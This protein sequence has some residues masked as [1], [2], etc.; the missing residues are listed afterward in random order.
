MLFIYVKIILGVSMSRKEV[1]Q[2][3]EEEILNSDILSINLMEDNSLELISPAIRTLFSLLFA[4]KKIKITS[5]FKTDYVSSVKNLYIDVNGTQLLRKKK[6]NKQDLVP[7]I[8]GSLGANEVISTYIKLEQDKRLMNLIDQNDV[9]LSFSNLYYHKKDERII[10]VAPI[11]LFKIKVSQYKDEYYLELDYNAPLFNEPLKYLLKDQFDIDISYYYETFD[12]FEY[13]KFI[14]SKLEGTVFALDDALMIL[15]CNV[16]NSNRLAYLVDNKDKLIHTDV[17]R[18]IDEPQEE[19]KAINEYHFSH[20]KYIRDS[21]NKLNANPVTKISKDSKLGM[22]FIKDLIDEYVLS[23]KN[24]LVLSGNEEKNKNTRKTLINSY[25]DMYMSYKDMTKPNTAIYTPLESLQRKRSYFLDADVS[26][27]TLDLTDTLDKK[28]NYDV[29]LKGIQLPTLEDNITIFNNYF[30]YLNLATKLYNLDEFKEYTNENYLKD[31]A[32]LLTL[33]TNPFF[34]D[35]PISKHPFDGLNNELNERDYEKIV[36]FLT[37]F[38]EDINELRKL[39]ELIKIK[40]TNWSKYNRLSELVDHLS[41]FDLLHTYNGFDTMFFSI[42]DNEPLRENLKI[43][44]EC[45]RKEAS[46]KLAINISTNEKIWTL[47]FKEILDNLKGREEKATRKLI[48]SLLKLNTRPNY[49]SLIVLIDKYEENRETMAEVLPTLPLELN[50]Y[51]NDVDG[52]NFIEDALDFIKALKLLVTST[53]LDFDND[54]IKTL[55]TDKEFADNFNRTYFDELVNGLETYRH[56]AS[57]YKKYFPGD[58]TSFSSTAFYDI[59]KLLEKRLNGNEEQFGEYLIFSKQASEASEQLQFA[60]DQEDEN[61]ISLKDF[62][63]NYM[64]SLYQ[65]LLKRAMKENDGVKLIEDQSENN[66]E[67]Y[68]KIKENGEMLHTKMNDE[69]EPLRKKITLQDSYNMLLKKLKDRYHKDRYFSIKDA[70]KLA[71]PYY[72]KVYPLE[73]KSIDFVDSLG[74][75]KFDLVIM[76]VDKDTT[77]LDIFTALRFSSKVL[78]F[79]DDNEIIK[80]VAEIKFNLNDDIG[81]IDHELDNVIAHV[82]QSLKRHNIELKKDYKVDEGVNIPLYFEVDNDRFALRFESKD[83]HF[84]EVDNYHL[85][86]DLLLSYNIKVVTLYLL[87]YIV[88]EDFT[89]L[90]LYNDISKRMKKHNYMKDP[91]ELLSYDQQRRVKYFQ[92]LDQLDHSFERYDVNDISARSLEEAHLKS[93]TIEERPIVTISPFEVADGILRYL[94]NFTYLSKDTL[95]KHLAK[96]I[97]TDELDIDYRL[98]FTKSLNILLEKDKVKLSGNRIYL[99]REP[100]ENK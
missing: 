99:N 52:I 68:T 84:S 87:P 42:Y 78:F 51:I 26:I 95:I 79:G 22:S 63:N 36:K 2:K 4:G 11:I 93:S 61:D 89:I 58:D 74:N 5:L 96:I 33:E 34:L 24:V 94:D 97:G 41:I 77:P 86:Q 64:L 69:F 9:Y 27:K 48:R 45:Y 73:T 70:L 82:E 92:M 76:L 10:S 38:K 59:L 16:L 71:G 55:F 56:D 53:N 15:K 29:L 40:D 80:N 35:N 12:I 25:F 54:F 43:L 30:K 1:F 81:T 98:L 91:L 90:A 18:A 85:P 88:Y 75:E 17:Y 62:K 31:Q 66:F 28:K 6:Y 57:K 20:P 100:K 8:K 39:I 3:F 7:L 47:N 19:N 44:K 46:M 60:L 50:E 65:H 49:E 21:L 72:Y 67:V 32:F 23:S 83:D 13:V 14:K 37:Q